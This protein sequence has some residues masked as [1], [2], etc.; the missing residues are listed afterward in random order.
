MG[1]IYQTN[2]SSANFNSDGVLVRDVSDTLHML[3]PDAGPFQVLTSQLRERKTCASYK[4]EWLKQGLPSTV[5]AF[6]GAEADVAHTTLP[7]HTGEL[8]QA[9]QV[10]LNTRTGEQMRVTSVASDVITVLRG[11]GVT[12]A[13][14][15]LDDDVV[16]ILANAEAEGASAPSIIS[17]GPDVDY[18][19][20]QNVKTPFGMT[21][22]A[23]A[24]TRAGGTYGGNDQ[25]TQM[26]N[27]SIAHLRKKELQM[28]F[29]ERK[30]DSS[31]FTHPAT[32]CGG[33]REF[34]TSNV[35]NVNGNLTEPVMQTFIR[36][37]FADGRGSDTRVCICDP[38]Y[39]E[40]L[41]HWHKNHVQTTINDERF[42]GK[43]T[44]YFSAFGELILKH[45][46][47]LT[48]TYGYNGWLFAIDPQYFGYRYLPENDDHI[49]YNIQTPGASL[50]TDQFF[51]EFTIELPL[52]EVHGRLYGTTGY[53]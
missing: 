20:I 16:L 41:T 24:I 47:L 3:Y 33:L 46:W 27:A 36:G 19:Y 38:I 11:W 10:V 34:V 48:S 21:T 18:N 29:G 5:D 51:T 53:V 22:R 44:R 8:F 9:G 1:T 45:S 15:I 2:K 23:R 14:A 42:G 13:A 25:N 28:L 31:N 49:E 50:V 40:A 37:V 35:T 52:P 12:S 39:I 43:V 17:I 26:K 6:D 30:L 4:V 32:A 7:V